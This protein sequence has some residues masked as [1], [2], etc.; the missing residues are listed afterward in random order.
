MPEQK[1]TYEER[2]ESEFVSMQ[3]DT[4]YAS[5]TMAER[6]ITKQAEAIREYAY[7]MFTDTGQA[8]EVLEWEI[9]SWLL[10]HGYI[11]PKPDR[12]LENLKE[13]EDMGIIEPKTEED[14]GIH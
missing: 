14:G 9:D 3:T 12:W 10:E 4:G 1:M 13:S 6:N 2:K 11:E 7:S 8:D 5:W